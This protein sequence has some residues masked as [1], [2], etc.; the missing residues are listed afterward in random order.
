MFLFCFVYIAK[1]ESL[2]ECQESAFRANLSSKRRRICSQSN[3]DED[4]S[5]AVHLQIF[6]SAT[7]N[8]GKMCAV[9]SAFADFSEVIH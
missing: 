3:V 6:S 7:S 5:D 8:A 4:L 1:K 2:G 9:D